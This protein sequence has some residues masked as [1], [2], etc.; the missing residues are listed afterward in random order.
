MSTDY[1]RVPSST[2]EFVLRDVTVVDTADGA[3]TGGQD[4]RISGGTI[5]GIGP[6]GQSCGAATCGRRPAWTA[7][8]PGSRPARP[9]ASAQYATGQ[10]AT[11]QCTSGGLGWVSRFRSG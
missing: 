4:V 1:V 2:G 8:W 7:C 9:F 6:A 10:C 5:A 3:R 11:S